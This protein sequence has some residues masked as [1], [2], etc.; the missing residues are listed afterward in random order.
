[1]SEALIASHLEPEAFGFYM[2]VG[3]QKN[4]RGNVLFFEIDEKLVNDYF[5]LKDIEQRFV[6]HLHE[7][8]K[9]SKYIS[10]YRVLEHLEL[11]NFKKLY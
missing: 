4:S 5:H 6:P 10:I 1:M 3:T 9:Q 7:N 2:V 11:P 8:P